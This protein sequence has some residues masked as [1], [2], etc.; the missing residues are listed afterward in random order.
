MSVDSKEV[1]EDDFD[2]IDEIRR[3]FGSCFCWEYCF[4]VHYVL[5]LV[6]RVIKSQVDDQLNRMIHFEAIDVPL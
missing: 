4:V 6:I 1:F 3:K 2:M 5:D